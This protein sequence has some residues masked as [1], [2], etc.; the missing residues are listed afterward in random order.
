MM[1]N[2]KVK[3]GLLPY[4]FLLLI[5]LGVLYFVTI[6][7]QKINNLTYSEFMKA[8]DSSELTELEVKP[9]ESASIYEVSG[10]LKNYGKNE[11]FYV[12]LPLSE[13]VMKKLVTASDKYNF[14]FTAVADPE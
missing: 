8:L 12:R 7:T 1:K 13:Q 6:A 3:Q 4:V 9:R 14:E 5:M 2:K 10:K 11:T